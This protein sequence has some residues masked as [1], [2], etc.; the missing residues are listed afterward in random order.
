[1]AGPIDPRL[2]RRAR[3]TRGYLVAGVAVGSATAILTLGQ[4]WLL[5]HSVADIF[6]TGQLG[7]LGLAVGGLAAVFGLKALLT[8]ANEWLAQRASAAVK[9]QLRQDIL[10]ARIE[11]PLDATSSGG[12]V[13]LITQGLDGLDGY[14]SKYLP[15]LLLAVTVPLVVGVAILSADLLSAVILAI[16]LP[17]IPVFMALVGWTTEAITKRR[18]AVQTRLANHFADLIAGLPTL[19][20]FGRARAQ[21]EG[22][23]RSETRHRSET[24]RTLRVSFLSA[25]VLELLATL[26]VA[27]IAVTVGFRVV[28]G[29]LDLATA[30]FVLIL[31][32]EA[33]LPVRQVG[34]HYH[35]AADGLAAVE[36]AFALIDPPEAPHGAGAPAPVAAPAEGDATGALLSVRELTH[37]YPGASAVALRPVSFDVRPGEVVALAGPSGAGKTTLLNAVLG[38]L[39]PTGGLLLSGGAPLGR[40]PAWREHLAF[41]GQEPGLVSGTVADNVRLGF[42]HATDA[43]VADALRQAGAGDIPL[44]QRIGDDAEGVS[45]GERRRIAVARALLRVTLG[46]AKLLVLDE[47]TA[48]LDADTEAGLLR[49]LRSLG[50]AALVVSHRPAVLAEAD[51]VVRIGDAG[52][53]APG[54]VAAVAVAAAVLPAPAN[55]ARAGVGTA[56]TAGVVAP[57]EKAPSAAAGRAAT[58]AAGEDPGVGDGGRVPLLRR[59]LDAVPGARLRLVGSVALAFCAT[60]ASVALMAVSAWLLS[61]AAEHPPVLYL[62]AAAVGVRFFGISRGAFRYVERLVGHDVALKLQSALRLETYTR[63]ARTTLLG[64]RRGDLLTR[65]IADVEAIQDLVVRVWIPFAS[66]AAVLVVTAIG[67]GWFSPGSALVLLGTSVLA[68]AV[69]PWLTRLASARA[70]AA[71]LPLR[72][73]LADSA[74]ELS[75]VATDLVAYGAAGERLAAFTAIDEELRRASARSAWVRG[76]GSA[77]QVLAAGIA[78]AGALV[79]GGN[80]VHDGTMAPVMLAVAVLTPLALHEAL[81]TLILSAQTRTR[82]RAALARV[83]AVLDAE[84]VGSGDLADPGVEVS[85]PALDVVGLTAGWPGAAPVVE[86]L[87]FGVRAGEKVALVGPS[88]IGKTTVAATALGLIPARAGEV[89]VRGRIGYLAQDAHIFTT[90]IAENVRIGNRDATDAD[91]ADALARAGLDLDP[92]RVVGEGGES[93]SGGEARR[94]ALS[95]LLVGHYQVLLLDE[96]TEHLDA[97]TASA[98]IDDIWAGSSDKPVLV[99]TH[100]PDLVARCD[101]VV[102]LA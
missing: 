40:L 45:A 71:S 60:A 102:R 10:A 70:D 35:D 2:L 80:Q 41:V 8:W 3:A 32:P 68:A 29:D 67:I 101:R 13:T 72:G 28:F 52:A 87:S 54:P 6:A 18:W 51:R 64:T 30:L 37:T 55:G 42:P 7:T 84:P 49:S 15:Q 47:P 90:T 9:S 69:V 79:I 82:A 11:R 39:A 99:I 85:D 36:S 23:R 83:E 74:R 75:R 16:T 1:M 61:R 59:L 62:E 66:S 76:I 88:G 94:V 22:L 86:G 17:L 77:A 53:E 50:V 21:A 100:D 33:Y 73:Q 4:A 78:V 5:S 58:D 93:L 63:L 98:L 81:S 19:Q 43:A 31:A 89:R 95:R 34:V 57:A 97:V 27:V 26:S 92:G 20:V 56:D 48:G 44:D 91:I 12:L 96:P 14:F 25:L 46:R 24:M 38:F 65:V